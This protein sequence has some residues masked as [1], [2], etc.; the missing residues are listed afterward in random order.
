MKSCSQFRIRKG[1]IYMGVRYRILWLQMQLVQLNQ[2]VIVY[3]I[4]I[5]G[6][7]T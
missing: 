6:L 1:F 5:R 2:M 7:I 3:N 4:V